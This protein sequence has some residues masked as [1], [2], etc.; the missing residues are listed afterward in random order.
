LWQKFIAYNIYP[1]VSAFLKQSKKTEDLYTSSG[2]RE[3]H[4]G[5]NREGL[6]KKLA[7]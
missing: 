1:N 5:N 4:E 3:Y 6:S 2:R 7:Q